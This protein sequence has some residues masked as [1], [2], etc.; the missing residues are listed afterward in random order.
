[1]RFEVIFLFGVFVL[2][3]CPVL[4]VIAGIMWNRRASN[5]TFHWTRT[6]G[7]I[8]TSEVRIE[9]A[10]GENRPDKYFACVRYAY[11]VGDSTLRN[12]EIWLNSQHQM[13][14]L[15]EANQVI[16]RYPVGRGVPVLYNPKNPE[17]AV[18]DPG[19]HAEAYVASFR[20]AWYFALLP[21][22][23]LIVFILALI[24]QIAG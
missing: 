3:C 5:L 10:A 12:D 13:S 14:T 8:E 22:L 15:E 7:E 11:I 20:N 21:A 16:S 2:A 18:L 1:M 9:E 4:G 24:A 17:S 6:H 19:F 23:M